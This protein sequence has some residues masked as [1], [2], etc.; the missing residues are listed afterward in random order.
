M[1]QFIFENLLVVGIVS[2]DA[3]TKLLF[4]FHYLFRNIKRYTSLSKKKK[5]NQYGKINHNPIQY[6]YVEI[7]SVCVLI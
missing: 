5:M 1:F 7:F 4:I 2:Q 3:E 6:R